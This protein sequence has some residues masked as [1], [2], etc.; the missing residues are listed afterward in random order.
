MN[1]KTRIVSLLSLFVVALLILAPVALAYDGRSG[2]RVVIAKGEVINDDLFVGGET[3]IVDGTINGDLIAAGQTVTINGKVTGNVVAAGSSV[4]VNG[5]VGHDVFAA[6]AVVT[7]GPN[8][9]IGYNAYTVGA[10]VESQAGQP[11]RRLAAHR[12]RPGPGFG[13]DHQRS[14]GGRRSPAPGRHGGP[15][16]QDR[17]RHLGDRHRRPACTARTCRRCPT[18]SLA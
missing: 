1:R 4:I 7:I 9:R 15:Q 14:A 12:R 3:V 16:C 10:S 17:R 5:E 8:A 18:S 11:D 6:G 2:K 13:A